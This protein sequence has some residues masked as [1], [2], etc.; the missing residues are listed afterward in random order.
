[1]NGNNRFSD[2]FLNAFVDDQLAPEEKS[3]VYPIVSQ[4]EG[5]NQRVCELR[6]MRDLVQ[7]AYKHP[8]MPSH[9]REHRTARRFG[10]A[11][12]ACL[13]LMIGIT[14]G[15]L[16]HQGWPAVHAPGRQPS[17]TQSGLV[18]AANTGEAKVLFH[19][20]SGKADRMREVL[21]EAEGLLKLYHDTHRPARVE[22]VANG[23]GI[24][25]LRANV[26]PFRARIAAMQRRYPNLTFAACQNTIDR[27][28]EDQGIHTHLVPQAIIVDSGVAQIIRLQRQGWAYI[29]V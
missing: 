21:D 11:V 7:L 13:M 12:A 16:L 4:D 9:R 27:M 24:D 25:L 10:S 17:S 3:R 26:T 29:Q 28:R 14:L 23:A 6:K 5:L 15:W 8:P 18:A 22:I 2:E 20:S 19:L 1:M